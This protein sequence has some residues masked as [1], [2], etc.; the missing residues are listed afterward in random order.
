M[1]NPNHDTHV[2]D[3][4]PILR[5]SGKKSATSPAVDWGIKGDI[6]RS[7]EAPNSRKKRSR[8]AGASNFWGDKLPYPALLL[9]YKKIQIQIHCKLICLHSA[10]HANF[11]QMFLK[12]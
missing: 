6:F 3:S 10:W 7:L 2:S 5:K 4:Y 1:L 11:C 12:S 9:F 8:A